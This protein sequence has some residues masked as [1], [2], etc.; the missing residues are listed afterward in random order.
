M[1][2]S[3]VHILGIGT[4]VLDIILQVPH[5]F[6]QYVPGEHGG[7]S[8]LSQEEIKQLIN[9][10]EQRPLYLPGGSCANTLRGL[11]HL[12]HPCTMIGSIGG[13]EEGA[14]FL[15]SFSSLPFTPQFTRSELTTSHVLSIVTPDGE[16]TMRTFVGAAA[17]MKTEMLQSSN[18]KDIR[19]I[20]IEGYQLQVPGLIEHAIQLA[21]KTICTISL[22]LG[23]FEVAREQRNR[24]L[25][26]SPHLDILFCNYKEFCQLAPSS[27][28]LPPTLVITKGAEGCWVTNK[29]T[30][31]HYPALPVKPI[32]S[33]GAGDLFICG[34][35]HEHLKGAPPEKCCQT[36]AILAAEVV[37]Y[38]G[39]AI[40]AGCWDDLRKVINR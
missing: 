28:S 23:S 21:R 19:H 7:A 20:H 8:P 12:G 10:S 25:E 35:L 13:D 30:T 3:P 16:R 38:V 4:P 34:F 1:A 14:I 32:D 37:K 36:A 2:E 33:T 24:I 18:L 40:P 5:T 15:E 27:D 22:D 17:D 39:A 26:L 6:M 31:V 9:Q 29:K 11:C